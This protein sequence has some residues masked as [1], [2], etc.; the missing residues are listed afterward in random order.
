MKVLKFGGTS[1]GSVENIKNIVQIVGDNVRHGEQVV[2]V[3]S[4]MSG[5]T[6]NLIETGRMAASGNDDY[7]SL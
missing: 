6:N 1:V 7:K 3:F 5:I 4:A 2:L